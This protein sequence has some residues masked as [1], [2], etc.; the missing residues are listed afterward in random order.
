MRKTNII[1][2]ILILGMA[3]GWGIIYWIFFADNVIGG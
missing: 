2:F 1:L 3:I